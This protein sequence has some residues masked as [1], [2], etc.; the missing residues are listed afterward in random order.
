MRRHVTRQLVSLTLLLAWALGDS[1]AS[2]LRVDQRLQRAVV[3]LEKR[4]DPDA[5]AAAALIGNHGVSVDLLG[6]ALAL[7]PDRPDLLWLQIQLCAQA[8]DCH[9]E[10]VEQRLQ[11]LDPTNA[12]GWLRALT[13]AYAAK[14]AAAV[15]TALAAMAHTEHLD[16]Y[17]T[18]L[19]GSLSTA[20]TSSGQ[21]SLSEAVVAV[22]GKTSA[23]AVPAYQAASK[24][25]QGERL[26]RPQGLDDCRAVA[27]AL[28]RGD[29]IIT[30]MMGSSMAQRLWPAASPES[31]AAAAA[32]RVQ[33]YRSEVLSKLME[34]DLLTEPGARRFVQEL[35]ESRRE[36][37]MILAE[38]RFHHI[39]PDP[40]PDWAPPIRP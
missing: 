19:I 18:R 30:T 31:L 4:N 11:V 36:Q 7:A 26:E 28:Q 14:D 37:D 23:I 38:L 16:I 27:V 24:S 1:R 5:L 21:V 13:R 12:A 3:A 2:D 34:P 35:L 32:R 25:C 8:G 6:H 17:W 22:L 33:S 29:T 15:D 20:L 40:A 39:A 10:P 9:S